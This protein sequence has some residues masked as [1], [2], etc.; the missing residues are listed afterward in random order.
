MA[1]LVRL[2]NQG[3]AHVA[4]GSWTQ[5]QEAFL[6]FLQAVAAETH[7]A[8]LPLRQA[9]LQAHLDLLGCAEALGNR[10][11]GLDHGQR[12]LELLL[13]GSTFVV[14]LRKAMAAMD[15]TEAVP[16]AA[17]ALVNRLRMMMTKAATAAPSD[18]SP[19]GSPAKT[20]AAQEAAAFRAVQELVV[21]L[22]RLALVALPRDPA[23][24]LQ[25]VAL[26]HSLEA[27][28]QAAQD[29]DGALA[30]VRLVALAYLRANQTLP[31][32]DVLQCAARHHRAEHGA[33]AEARSQA[34]ALALVLAVG[35]GDDVRVAR[36]RALHLELQR[37]PQEGLVLLA[38][39][40]LCRDPT[41]AAE[42]LAECEHSGWQRALGNGGDPAWTDAVRRSQRQ[43]RQTVAT[44]LLAASPE[45]GES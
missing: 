5:A 19:R 13:P 2:F 4:A 45:A 16:A 12:A 7:D 33:P 25:W 14:R 37:E 17:Q 28:A 9:Q 24:L 22:E 27:E 41:A 1:A 10:D 23:V 35:L 11:A 3:K 36:A 40:W 18:A 32:C 34:A 43:M 38:D 20:P 30:L 21:R 42:A 6:R 29:G 8:A 39:A 15:Y 26:R 44:R 31:A